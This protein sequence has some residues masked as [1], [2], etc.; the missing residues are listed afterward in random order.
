MSAQVRTG[1]CARSSRSRLEFDVT[2]TLILEGSAAPA[3]AVEFAVC[4]PDVAAVPPSTSGYRLAVPAGTND[5]I[6]S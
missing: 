5:C 1:R 3:G 2:S 6:D 4:D